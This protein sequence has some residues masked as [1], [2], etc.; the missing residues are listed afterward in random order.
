MTGLDRKLKVDKVIQGPSG[1]VF[2]AY[3][4]LHVYKCLMEQYFRCHR[5][6]P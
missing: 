5:D 1:R 3:Y 2:A 4:F 6:V